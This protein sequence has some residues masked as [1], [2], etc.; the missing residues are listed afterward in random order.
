[1]RNLVLETLSYE[2]YTIGRL[3]LPNGK[4]FMTLELPWKNNESYVSCIPAGVYRGFTRYSP[5]NKARVIE[6]R[7]VPDRTHIQI[8]IANYVSSL[9]GCIAV[10]KGLGY[11][12][13]GDNKPDLTHSGNAFLELMRSVSN[14]VELEVIRHGVYD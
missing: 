4:Y 3:Q 2:D 11:D 12:L 6:L 7:D 10:G 8:H 1:M 14:D 13:N 9:E 5:K